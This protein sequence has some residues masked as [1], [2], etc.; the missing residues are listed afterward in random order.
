MMNITLAGDRN[1]LTG[2]ELVIYSTMLHNKN[3]N[4]RILTMDIAIPDQNGQMR[5]FCGITDEPTQTWLKW[6][7]HFMDYNS[8]LE[9]VDCA[10]LYSTHLENSINRYTG[11]TPYASLRLLADLFMP[12]ET[13]PNKINP[14]NDFMLYLDADTIVQKNIESMYWGTLKWD[15]NYAAYT[16]P[17]ACGGFGELISAVILFNI[18][19]IRYTGLLNN[20]RRNYNTKRYP[21]PDQGA[22][23]DAGKPIPLQE[24]YNYM[25]DHKK[26]TYTPH[27]IHFSNENYTKIY[28]PNIPE[29]QF[30][31]Y[32]PEHQYLKVGLDSAKEI[33]E[34]YH[35]TISVLKRFSNMVY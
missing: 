20:A 11:F 14:D 7:V 16:L 25:R 24:T 31:K 2:I 30:W 23:F 28:N 10:E 17:E 9:F 6:L 4:W 26:C 8:T 33:F 27:I 34:N 19:R 29:G 3:I 35:P 18:R 5:Q 12:T 21:Y 13:D 1:V 15:E 32:Y 22:L